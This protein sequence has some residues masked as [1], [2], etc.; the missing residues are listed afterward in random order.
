[1]V[2][3]VAQLSVG[4]WLVLTAYRIVRGLAAL[5]TFVVCRGRE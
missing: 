5:V 1:M 4:I 3:D 2:A